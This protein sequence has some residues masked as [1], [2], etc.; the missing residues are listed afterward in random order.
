[1]NIR[2]ANDPHGF[3]LLNDLREYIGTPPHIFKAETNIIVPFLLN[4]FLVEGKFSTNFPTNI[5][6][7]AGLQLGSGIRNIEKLEVENIGK[8]IILLVDTHTQD[9]HIPNY[10]LN[11]QDL[12]RVAYLIVN[13]EPE[14]G[15]LT[16][17]G[18]IRTFYGVKLKQHTF[19]ITEIDQPEDLFDH[20]D[21]LRKVYL[22]EN[23]LHTYQEYGWYSFSNLSDEL[24]ELLDNPRSIVS[25]SCRKNNSSIGMSKSIKLRVD[26]HLIALNITF[27][28]LEHILI[29]EIAALH[30]LNLPLGLIVKLI[31]NGYDGL[32]EIVEERQVDK[33]E[34][35]FSIRFK[36]I[37]GDQFSVILKLNDRYSATQF[38]IP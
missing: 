13:L 23:D 4:K 34:N 1:M 26:N 11:F 7:L 28:R 31:S 33:S 18:F 8:L 21:Q 36:A 20:L 35:I 14:Y 27:D 12:D 37:S 10:L 17:Y 5:N 3:E 19:S 24:L 30:S 6:R 29:I 25:N 2:V 32:S 22:S 15:G 9:Y 38:I 16:I